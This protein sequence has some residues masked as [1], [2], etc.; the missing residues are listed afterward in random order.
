MR[1]ELFR[2]VLRIPFRMDDFMGEPLIHPY[3]KENPAECGTEKFTLLARICFY[4][5]L[6][7]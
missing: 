2:L 6:Q 1:R 5:D 3:F 4:A 7:Q